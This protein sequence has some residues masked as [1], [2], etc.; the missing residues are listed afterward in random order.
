MRI[1]CVLYQLEYG[2]KFF[3]DQILANE[4]LEAGADLEWGLRFHS[5]TNR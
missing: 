1:K 4:I 2:N 5:P 3:R